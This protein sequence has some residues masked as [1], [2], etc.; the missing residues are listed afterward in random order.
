[1]LQPSLS[2]GAK[3]PDRCI[4]GSACPDR[5]VEA[6]ALGDEEGGARAGSCGDA[7][8]ALVDV[9]A[10]L[11]HVEKARTAAEIDPLARGIEEDIVSIAADR[12]LRHRGAGTRVEHG[13]QRG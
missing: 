11:K 7:R 8:E 4:L 6:I 5:K 13:E 1:M 10:P 9:T 3:H 12:Q 2:R